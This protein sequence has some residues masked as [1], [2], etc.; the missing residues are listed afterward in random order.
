MGKKQLRAA[1]EH[2]PVSPKQC[3]WVTRLRAQ[4]GFRTAAVAFFLTVALGAGG[5]AAYA[6]WSASSSG[7]IT[8]TTVAPE[9][10]VPSIGTCDN[11]YLLGARIA[12]PA[13]ATA[14][15]EARVVLTFRSARLK[16]PI[17]VALPQS[18]RTAQAVQPIGL[19]LVPDLGSTNGRLA[20]VTVTAQTA[21][22]KSPKTDSVRV[23][24][25]DFVHPPSRESAPVS[26]TYFTTPLY[27]VPSFLCKNR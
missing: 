27:D 25:T 20:D 11:L 2:G 24:G 18:A 10:P 9:T 12:L 7:A 13:Q 15:P 6:W 14:D 5:P 23:T 4:P 22:L 1:P 19:G 8:G 17:L 21:I 16:N 26:L 3:G